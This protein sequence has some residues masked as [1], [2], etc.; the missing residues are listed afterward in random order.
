MK[1]FCIFWKAV[2]MSPDSLLKSHQKKKLVCSIC[3][4]VQRSATETD[5]ACCWDAKQLRNTP[6]NHIMILKTLTSVLDSQ[7]IAMVN[8]KVM[9]C[10]MYVYMRLKTWPPVLNGMVTAMVNE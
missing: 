4:T 1:L 10:P 7:V 3:N 9:V 6:K 8:G 5:F 2:I